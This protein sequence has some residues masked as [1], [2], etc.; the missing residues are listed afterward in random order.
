MVPSE[1]EKG[2]FDID[3]LTTAKE[4]ETARPNGAKSVLFA[5]IVAT[6]SHGQ[7]ITDKD[8]DYPRDWR[9]RRTGVFDVGHKEAGRTICLHSLAVHPKLQGCGLGKM[10][11]KSYLQQVKNSGVADRISLLA[12]KV[13]AHSPRGSSL[14]IPSNLWCTGF[15]QVLYQTWLPGPRPKQD[16]IWWWWVA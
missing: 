5:H 11:M 6:K 2:G 16:F 1:A 8:M 10:L 7:V 12:Q 14:V 13:S 4:V 3:M 9:T 15:G